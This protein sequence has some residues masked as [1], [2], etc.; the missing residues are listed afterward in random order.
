M[1]LDELD[2]RRPVKRQVGD[3]PVAVICLPGAG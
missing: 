2:G 3:V 1:P